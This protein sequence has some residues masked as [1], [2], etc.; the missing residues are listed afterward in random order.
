MAHTEY[1]CY[2][3]SPVSLWFYD[4]QWFTLII[5]VMV[6]LLCEPFSVY[7]ITIYNG[8][9]YITEPQLSHHNS[10]TYLNIDIQVIKWS[11]NESGNVKIR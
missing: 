9:H 5:C 11:V 8:E 2:G 3:F 7:A 1:M 6:S 10:S 4:M